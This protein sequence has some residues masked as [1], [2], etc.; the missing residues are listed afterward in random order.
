MNIVLRSGIAMGNDN[1]KQPQDNTWVHK[2]AEK[3]VEFDLERACKRLM[4]VKKS[5]AEA[6]TLGSQI[7]LLKKWSLLCLRHC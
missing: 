1:G 5:F 2:N 6:S 7:N 4:E 3:E